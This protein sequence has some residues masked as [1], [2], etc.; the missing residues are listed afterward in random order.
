[1]L[2]ATSLEYLSEERCDTGTWLGDGRR[3]NHLQVGFPR[4]ATALR[5]LPGSHQ[6]S[7]KMEGMDHG[8]NMWSSI[9]TD[10]AHRYWYTIAGFVGALVAI[11]VVNFYK[12]QRRSVSRPKT[13]DGKRRWSCG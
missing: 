1:V 2:C 11:R 10:L 9:N 6:T 7:A 4:I 13:S 3:L 8:S 12:V 5:R